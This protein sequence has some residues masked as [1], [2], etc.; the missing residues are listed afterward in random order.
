MANH[1]LVLERMQTLVQKWE[2][3]SDRRSIFLSCY[4]L[5]THN[6]LAAIDGGEFE[7]PTWVNRLLHQF[8]DYYFDALDAYERDSPATPAVWRP[9]HNAAGR[10][11]TLVL[12]N[13]LLGINAHINYDLVLTL[14][15]MLEPEWTRLSAGEREQRYADYC[16]VNDIIGRTLD[17]VQDGVVERLVPAMDIVD[18]MLGPIDEWM[19]SRLLTLWRDEVWNQAVRLIE[20]SKPPEREELRQQIE[21]ATL[22]RAEAILLK[23]IPTALKHLV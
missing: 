23:D 14:V 13:L 22:K 3:A 8:A 6:M 2:E 20:T 12:Q 9:A 16:Y 7:N 1:S 21:A 15:D 19:V 18:K 4:T 5:M 17:A 11:E 10:S